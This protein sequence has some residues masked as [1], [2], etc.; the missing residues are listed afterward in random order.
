MR[1]RRRAK[2]EA[3]ARATAEEEVPNACRIPLSKP[4]QLSIKGAEGEPRRTLDVRA[5][6]GSLQDQIRGYYL[7][8]ISRLPTADLNTTL[9]RGLLIAGH[10]HGYGPLH[11]VHNI[12]LNSIW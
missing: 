4:I 12:L 7:D 11:P 1:N 8:A 6:R 2:E 3:K 10:G 5:A 9:A